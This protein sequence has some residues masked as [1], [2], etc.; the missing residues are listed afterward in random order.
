MPSIPDFYF[1]LGLVLQKSDKISE[2]KKYFAK[3]D[4]LIINFVKSHSNN[5]WKRDSLIDMLVEYK[6]KEALHKCGIGT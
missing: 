4:K 6:R 2:A 3:G 5:I 1:E